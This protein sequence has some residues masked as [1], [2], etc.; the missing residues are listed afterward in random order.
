MITPVSSKAAVRRTVLVSHAAVMDAVAPAE[1]VRQPKVVIIIMSVSQN[2]DAL[3]IVW[4]KSAGEMIVA[5]LA[6]P[7]PRA[8]AANST[9]P[10]LTQVDVLLIVRG[11]SAAA[12]VVVVPAVAVG[13]GR[14]AIPAV[15]VWTLAGV[16]HSV[17]E[18]SAAEMVVVVLAVPAQLG[19]CAMAFPNA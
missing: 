11:C 7:V 10:A 14:A 2:R 1:H 4:V 3:L 16:L 19:T 8:V 9:I 5:G 18:R 15:S 13:Q 6:A 17:L 12:T